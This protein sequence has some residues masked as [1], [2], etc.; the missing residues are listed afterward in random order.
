LIR[1]EVIVSVADQCLALFEDGECVAT[2]PIS[3]SKFGVGS[4]NGSYR[5]P[6]GRMKIVE[7]IGENA[8]IGMVFKARQPT[9][10]VLRPNAPGRDPI[11]TRILRLEGLDAT[12]RN[13][14][15]RCIYIHGTPEERTIGRP[16][17]YG[18][19]RMKSG[20]M[21]D[22][23]DAVNAGTNLTIVRGTL[24]RGIYEVV[25]NNRQSSGSAIYAQSIIP[26]VPV[27][28]NRG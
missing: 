1:S 5:T 13:T 16:A 27:R 12:N 18:C 4:K 9:G 8:P 28:T 6:E 25:H 14:F 23:F 3:T 7:K 19:I 24:A 21:V 15:S 20:D 2:H 22:L 11:V 10:E 17:S 26:T